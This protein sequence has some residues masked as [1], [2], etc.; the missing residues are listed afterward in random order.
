MIVLID[1]VCVPSCVK[2]HKFRICLILIC[3]SIRLWKMI[4]NQIVVT[5]FLKTFK[6]ENAYN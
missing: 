3:L 1:N 2:L 4:L 6:N 5:D